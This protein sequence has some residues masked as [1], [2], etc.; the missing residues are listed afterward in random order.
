[1]TVRL[2][3]TRRVR[4]GRHHD[5]VRGRRHRR[6]VRARGGAPAGRVRQPGQPRAA[7][8][9]DLGAGLPRAAHR[10]HRPAHRRAARVPDR[11]RAQRPPAAAARGRPAAQRAGGRRRFS[12]APHRIDVADIVRASVEAATPV[13]D[14]AGV[15]LEASAVATPLDGDPVRLAQAVDNLVSNA[16]KFT[17]SGGT[18][19]VGVT[20]NASAR[21]GRRRRGHRHRHPARRAVPADHPV[22]PGVDGHPPRHPGGRASGCR[23]PRRSSTRTGDGSRSPSTLGEGTTFTI[24]LPPTPPG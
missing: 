10:R 9:A 22:L 4:G 1:M 15:R 14:A 7:D 20:P 5:G 16:I 13:A 23:S 18:V 21:R 8:P 11:H 19:R 2:A 3:V 17:P 12:I 24:T 6:D